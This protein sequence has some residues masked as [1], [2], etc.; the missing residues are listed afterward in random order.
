[1]AS[2]FVAPHLCIL[3]LNSCLTVIWSFRNFSHSDN[4]SNWVN[5]S[6][7]HSLDYLDIFHGRI[8]NSSILL[9]GKKNVVFRSYT[10][11]LCLLLL[12]TISV[13]VQ[14]INLL[15]RLKIS[16]CNTLI[17]SLHYPCLITM[18]FLLQSK[19]RYISKM[20]VIQKSENKPKTLQICPATNSAKDYSLYTFP[21]WSQG[22]V[23]PIL[24]NNDYSEL[25][26]CLFNYLQILNLSMKISNA[27]A[28]YVQNK[29]I[30]LLLPP[31]FSISEWMAL[32]SIEFGKPDTC[33]TFFFINSHNCTIRKAVNLTC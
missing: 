27:Q 21:A 22:W 18:P 14:S 31:K 9:S 16:P 29:F 17:F 19:D 4:R 30:I 20:W 11:F 2:K 24:N 33:D 10:P 12:L 3:L 1:M 7:S 32:L 26:I 8:F 15:F 28:Q 5:Y 25:Q 6:Y 23:S 13:F